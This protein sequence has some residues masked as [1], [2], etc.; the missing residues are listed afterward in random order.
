MPYNPGA[1]NKTNSPSSFMPYNDDN[2]STGPRRAGSGWEAI[3]YSLFVWPWEGDGWIMD[4]KIQTR[5]MR[6]LWGMLENM[7]RV[8]MD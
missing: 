2:S 8:D 6:S 1:D 4:I 3:L 7:G 5:Y